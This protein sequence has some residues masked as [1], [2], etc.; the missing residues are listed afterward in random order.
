MNEGALTY[1]NS[2]YPPMNDHGKE[3]GNYHIWAYLTSI[4][5]KDLALISLTSR[6]IH[7]AFPEGIMIS[8]YIWVIYKLCAVRPK[9]RDIIKNKLPCLGSNP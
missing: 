5:R 1:D 4:Q 8:Y 6:N 2:L 7:L 3:R 9:R